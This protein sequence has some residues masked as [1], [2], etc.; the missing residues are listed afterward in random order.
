MKKFFIIIFFYF[1]ITA[2][3]SASTKSGKGESEGNDGPPAASSY[4]LGSKYILAAEKLEKKGKIKKAKKK[5]KKAL[6]FLFEANEETSGDPDILYYLGFASSKLGNYE[7]A[8]IYY[9]LGLSFDPNHKGL[10]KHLGELY[11]TTDRKDKALKQLK[12][13]KTCNCEEYNK[14]KK[15]IGI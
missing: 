13:L 3:Y 5:Y 12:I 7:N 6:E 15:L 11:L 9:L 10:N 8:E 4:K 14:L 2:T 1:F